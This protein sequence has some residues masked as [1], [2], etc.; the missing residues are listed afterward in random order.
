[1]KINQELMKKKPFESMYWLLG[2]QLDLQHPWFSKVDG[3]RLFVI[4]EL[5][6]ET[7]YCTQHVQKICAFFLSM[8]NFA[9]GLRAKGH[10]V[11]HLTLDE[12]IAF[13]NLEH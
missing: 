6:Q 3:N 5:Y 13:D 1:M 10:Q 4:A 11:V 12:T 7:A 8:E 2:D 9:K